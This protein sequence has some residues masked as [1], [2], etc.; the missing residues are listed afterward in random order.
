MHN[1]LNGFIKSNLLEIITVHLYLLVFIQ[2]VVKRKT[3][4][5]RANSNSVLKHSNS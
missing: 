1:F 3:T 2:F 5:L 4:V